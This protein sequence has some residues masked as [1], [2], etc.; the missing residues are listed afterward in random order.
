MSRKPAW[1]QNIELLEGRKAELEKEITKLKG[2]KHTFFKGH[3]VI[4]IAQKEKEKE[5]IENKIN[6]LRAKKRGRRVTRG[7]IAGIVI[8][9]LEG[10][11]SKFAKKK[12]KAEAAKTRLVTAKAAM[13]SATATGMTTGYKTAALDRRIKRQ[14]NR[15]EKFKNRSVKV[16]GW[17]RTLLW[18]KYKKIIRKDIKNIKYNA[19]HD[20]KQNKINDIFNYAKTYDSTTIMGAIGNLKYTV[21]GNMYKKSAEVSEF[22]AEKLRNTVS[23]FKGARRITIPRRTFT[24]VVAIP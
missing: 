19:K 5:M 12:A 7:K 17:Q 13:T 10:K 21:R 1:E 15:I 14:E 24:P 18:P 11:D 23:I 2:E 8:S 3:H 4:V 16:K 22:F 6:Q 20:Y 9:I